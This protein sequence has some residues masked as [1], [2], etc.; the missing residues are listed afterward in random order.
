MED[1]LDELAKFD[2]KLVEFDKSRMSSMC[3]I[4]CTVSSMKWLSWT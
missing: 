4:S 3:W 1:E 2:F